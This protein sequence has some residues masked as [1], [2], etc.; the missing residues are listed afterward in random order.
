[1]QENVSC[2]ITTFPLSHG[3]QYFVECF[4]KMWAVEE[5]PQQVSF[6]QQYV[7]KENILLY[8]PHC[9]KTNFPADKNIQVKLIIQE[10]L[11][12]LWSFTDL[13]TLNPSRIM[14]GDN[15]LRPCNSRALLTPSVQ[16][17][18]LKFWSKV[19]FARSRD[20]NDF[21]GEG[22][23]LEFPNLQRNSHSV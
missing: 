7:K 2:K 1:M 10:C 6:P 9:H 19:Q 22:S 16:V 17:F 21:L 15:L 11:V 14:F 18:K 20:S 3:F 8:S 5:W 13:C 12:L 4:C 23:M